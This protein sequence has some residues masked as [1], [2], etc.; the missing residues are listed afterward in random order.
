MSAPNKTYD[1][2]R[3]AALAPAEVERMTAEGLAAIA[4]AGDLRRAEGGGGR[5]IGAGRR[6]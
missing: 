2:V 6:R 4:A 5:R 1:P 3:V